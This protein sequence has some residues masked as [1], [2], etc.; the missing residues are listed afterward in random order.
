[1]TLNF[2]FFR[3][4]FV[5]V[6]AILQPFIIYFYCGELSSISQVWETNL[7]FLFIITNALVSYFFFELDEWKIP[8]SFLL[9]LTAF[10]VIDHFWLHNIF[11]I[12]FFI[13]CLIPLYLTKRL[14]FYLPI[15]FLSVLLWITNGFFWMETWGILTLCSYH[16]HLIIY[17]Y[18]L[19]RKRNNEHT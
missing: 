18:L 2:D 3:R 1:M 11:A 4:L 14:K 10:S 9:L 15:Y 8:S 19:L 12:L 16:L 6:I 13:S 5:I 7:Q 17:R